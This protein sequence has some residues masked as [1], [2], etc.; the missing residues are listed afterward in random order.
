MKKIFTILI[1]VFVLFL[2]GCASTGVNQAKFNQHFDA[3]EYATCAE[4]LSK[5]KAAE[6]IDTAIDIS[7][8]KNYAGDYKGSLAYFNATNS[9]IDDAFTKS[10]TKG[11]AS[12][13]GNENASDYA[14][15]VYEYMLVNA[16]NSLNYFNLGELNEALV[17]IRIIENKQ[18]E[19][20]NKYGELILS[21]E[22]DSSAANV[23]AANLGID[24]AQYAQA[25]P[26]NAKEKDIYKD[27]SFAHYLA[28]LLYLQDR[29]GDP[30]LHEKEYR[31]L[32]PYGASLK[33]DFNIPWGMGRLDVIALAG[34]IKER[35]EASINI[36]FYIYD[37][38]DMNPHLK[39]VWPTV[40]GVP[41]G[42]YE[43]K[44]SVKNGESKKLGVVENFDEAVNKDVASKAKKAFMRSFI[45][46][47]VKEGSVVASAVVAYNACNSDLLR[48]IVLAG[49][50][51]AVNAVNLTETADVRQA[52]YLPGQV[53]GGGFTL[54]PGTYSIVVEYFSNGNLMYTDELDNIEVRANRIT[55]V[56]STGIFRNK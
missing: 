54:A 33:E 12:A 36:P 8:L 19:Y 49:I 56:Q 38:P 40:Y 14:G 5:T 52:K 18:K 4:M 48:S 37:I 35:T 27:S 51:P 3:G 7:L 9:A 15:N 31:A 25:I 6:S 46:S 29:S 26:D 2:A 21:E 42:N 22:E 55:M 45:R 44:V 13:V 39:Y 41:N 16:F 24:M 50:G 20:I 30:V 53:C 47:T 11:I 43:V 34:K 1:S 32:N 10:I 28:A 23:A 17:E